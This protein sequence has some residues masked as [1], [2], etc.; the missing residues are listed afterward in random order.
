ME[1][2]ADMLRDLELTFVDEVP[3]NGAPVELVPGGGSRL[4]TLDNRMEY[5]DALAQHRLQKAVADEMKLF[6]KGLNEIVTE[7]VMCLLDESDLELIMCGVAD[8]AAADLKDNCNIVGSPPPALRQMFNNTLSYLWLILESYSPDERCRF[9]QFVTG[10]AVLP[11]DGFAGLRPHFQIEAGAPTA[12][13]VAH[14]CFN[15][16]VLPVCASLQQLEG[17]LRIALT[18]GL[19]GF[20]LQ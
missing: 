12:L 17:K 2:D 18:E 7:D 16:L 14:T 15:M 1:A 6:L 11:A 3:G 4:V 8:Y 5:L 20:E 19:E 9:L 10:C 13:P